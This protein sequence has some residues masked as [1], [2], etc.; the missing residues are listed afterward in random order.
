MPE[1]V[2]WFLQ[3][4]DKTGSCSQENLCDIVPKWAQRVYKSV[5]CKI[6]FGFKVSVGCKL[7]LADII[8]FK[9]NSVPACL[10]LHFSSSHCV[11]TEAQ[12]LHWC[13]FSTLTFALT[14]D[15]VVSTMYYIVRDHFL[16]HEN[17][18][19]L[20]LFKWELKPGLITVKWTKNVC[21][22]RNCTAYCN[23]EVC[24]FLFM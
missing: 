10:R 11:Y 21:Y 18:D 2:C 7:I 15:N 13:W 4:P 17:I 8:L 5:K 3:M 22:K 24:F 19:F 20:V 6:E 9:K 1:Q 14:S 23:P 16:Q 12:C